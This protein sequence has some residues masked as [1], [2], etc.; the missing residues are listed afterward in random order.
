MNNIST[1]HGFALSAWAWAGLSGNQ[2]SSF[3]INNRGLGY[4]TLFLVVG[5]IYIVA[6]GIAISLFKDDKRSP[7]SIR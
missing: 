5:I 4:D 7:R 2:L 3:I 6:L 1:I